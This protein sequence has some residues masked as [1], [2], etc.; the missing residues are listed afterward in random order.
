MELSELEN[1]IGREFKDVEI[2]RTALT[3]RSYL[4]EHNRYPNP[5]NERL[6]FLG[7][8]I[9]QFLTSEYLYG[10]YP[11]EPEGV[12]TNYRAAIVCTKSLGEES[13]RLNF[14]K[15]LLLSHGEEASGG[16]AKEYILANT[17]EALLGAIYLDSH[18]L[19]FCR[20]YLKKNLFYK[21][22]RIVESEGFKDYKSHFQEVAQEEKG[23][24]PV[25]KVIKDWGPDHEKHFV[26]GVFLDSEE[27]AFGE[28][29]SKQRAEQAAALNA[30]EKWGKTK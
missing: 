16:R 19:S 6:E 22:I 29:S 12:L 24:T 9:L 30:L 5:S 15:F 26:V 28:G 20:E 10:N 3:H 14:G 8:A 27:V 21:I 18:D 4:N 7:D 13:A 17:F 2:L 23:I 11:S 25:Y 1:I